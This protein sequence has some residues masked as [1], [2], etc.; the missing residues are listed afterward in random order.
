MMGKRGGYT[1]EKGFDVKGED[2]TILLRKVWFGWI[3]YRPSVCWLNFVN[4]EIICTVVYLLYLPCH[5]RFFKSSYYGLSWLVVFDWSRQWW[6]LRAA[7]AD[8]ELATSDPKSASYNWCSSSCNSISICWVYDT[9]SSAW[10]ESHYG[11]VLFSFSTES[12]SHDSI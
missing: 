10:C 11:T 2:I 9:A 4:Q 8:T 7:K 12:C 1:W 3:C 5:L 6:I